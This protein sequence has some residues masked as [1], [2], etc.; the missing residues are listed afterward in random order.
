MLFYG[1]CRRKLEINNKGCHIYEYQT[2]KFRTKVK[3]I[4]GREYFYDELFLARY[5]GERFMH[6]V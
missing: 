4:I 5:D 6:E 3:G 1:I 2:S